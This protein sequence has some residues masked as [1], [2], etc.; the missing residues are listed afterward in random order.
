MLEDFASSILTKYL[1]KYILGLKKENLKFAL[2]NGEVDL[3]N[4]EINLDEFSDLDIPVSLI[5]GTLDK[6]KL[7]VPWKNLG[8]ES[9]II[10]I[11]NLFILVEPKR[12][13]HSED[14]KTKQKRLQLLEL[15]KREPEEMKSS[16]WTEYFSRGIVEKVI[17][18][19]QI[20][21]NSV[22][23]RIEDKIY[24]PN[25]FYSLGVTIDSFNIQSTD[26]NWVPNFIS[27]LNQKLLF[28]LADLQNLSIY[29]NSNDEPLKYQDLT[30]F[31]KS[32][33]SRVKI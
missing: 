25:N 22:H 13:S 20:K 5:K 6:L 11:Q 32:M 19:V 17:N 8:G 7:K 4:L 30:S 31:S 28:K 12:M 1:G 27:D 15:M 18:N 16:T 3:S 33:K 24:N 14:Q 26:S 10:D 21:I 2:S 9:M 29:F 23:L